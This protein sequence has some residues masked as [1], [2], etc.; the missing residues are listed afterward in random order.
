MFVSW[1][2]FLIEFNQL[3]RNLSCSWMF[4]SPEQAS[5]SWFDQIKDCLLCPTNLTVL[6]YKAHEGTP[7]AL[8][9]RKTSK[10]EKKYHFIHMDKLNLAKAKGCLQPTTVGSTGDRCTRVYELTQVVFPLNLLHGYISIH[11]QMI[12]Y[13]TKNQRLGKKGPNTENRFVYQNSVVSSSSSFTLLY[14]YLSR[15]ILILLPPL[16]NTPLDLT[17]Q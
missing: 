13:L 9:S 17:T 6:G 5:G 2:L 8:K 1:F 11:G 16:L 15:G 10:R 4:L 7:F 12:Q 3:K 14:W